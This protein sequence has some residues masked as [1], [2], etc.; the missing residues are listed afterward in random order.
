MGKTFDTFAPMGPYIVTA[1]EIENP[2]NLDI[3]CTI[4]GEVLQ[5]SNTRHLIFRI[6]DLIEYLSR[7]FTLE[8]GDIISTGTPAGVGFARKPPR[9]L[10]PG[11]EVVVSVQGL[12]ELRNPVVAE[13]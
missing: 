8:P 10:K 5:N 9:F 1:D 3:S 4:N 12:G 2:H 6:P 7:V 13:A 11:D